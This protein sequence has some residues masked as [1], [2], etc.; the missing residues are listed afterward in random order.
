ML[1]RMSRRISAKL[2]PD[3]ISPLFATRSGQQRYK[4]RFGLDRFRPSFRLTRPERRRI[5]IRRTAHVMAVIYERSISWESL[6]LFER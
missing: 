4:L 1:H 3:L 6:A 5:A 2:A